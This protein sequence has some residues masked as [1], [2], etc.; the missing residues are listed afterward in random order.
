MVIICLVVMMCLGFFMYFMPTKAVKK[1]DVN[2]AEMIKK[3]KRNG[4]ILAFI[5][6]VA[7]LVMLFL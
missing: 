1:E 5:S 3:S 2:N 6:L 4:I 7:I